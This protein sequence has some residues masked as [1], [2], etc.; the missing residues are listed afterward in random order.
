MRH[1][2]TEL[3]EQ[4]EDGLYVASIPELKGCH[5]QAQN[6]NELDLRIK[7]AIK[8]YFEVEND[9]VYPI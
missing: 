9:K 8:L 2:F 3:I 7:E 4:D 6:L 5:T 1:R